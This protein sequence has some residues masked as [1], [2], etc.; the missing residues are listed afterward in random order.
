MK[1]EPESSAL[2]DPVLPG[3]EREA[4]LRAEAELERQWLTLAQEVAGIGS[5]DL[6]LETNVNRWTPTLEAMYGLPPGAFG[7]TLEAWAA[8]VHPDDRAEALCQVEL[9]L[10]TGAPVQTEWRAIWPDRSIHWIL[11][12][13]Q[14]IGDE[15]G[16]PVRLTG[17]N[18]DITEQKRAQEAQQRLS[19]IVASSDTTP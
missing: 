10:Q 13:W 15:S 1:P 14:A 9:S 6:N 2:I 11:A 8:L 7:G 3:G 12:R 4:R 19:A 17:V 16:K 5:F 18:L